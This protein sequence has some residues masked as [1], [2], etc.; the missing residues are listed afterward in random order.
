[1]PHPQ[2]LTD[3]THL[4]YFRKVSLRHISTV[5]SSN[6]LILP[7]SIVST[8]VG[9]YTSL[10][11]NRIRFNTARPLA[12]SPVSKLNRLHTGRLRKRD[13]LLTGEGGGGEG[14]GRGAKS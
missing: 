11:T 9:K 2:F 6:I 5:S 12:P 13:N 3:I 8:V 7:R 14:D 4:S 1:M 10:D